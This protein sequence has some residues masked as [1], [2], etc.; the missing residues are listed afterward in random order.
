MITETLLRFH[1]P[2]PVGDFFVHFIEVRLGSLVLTHC[3]VDF[4]ILMTKPE[5]L[6]RGRHCHQ[7]LMTLFLPLSVDE[8][9]PG[10]SMRTP[11]S[12]LLL[13]ETELSN[14]NPSYFPYFLPSDLRLRYVAGPLV[15]APPSCCVTLAARQLG[16][17]P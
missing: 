8:H 7:G 13:C 9:P 11:S 10:L 17:Q 3:H 16:D 15:P 5:A 4:L 14:P 6:D 2:F 1:S 12:A